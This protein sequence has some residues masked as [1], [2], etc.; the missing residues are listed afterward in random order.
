MGIVIDAFSNTPG[1]HAAACTLAAFLRL[2]LIKIIKGDELPEM[3]S[4]SYRTFGYGGFLKYTLVFV[5][6]HHLALY[7]LESLTIFDPLFL[8]MR[9]GMGVVITT[10]LICIVDA[11]NIDTQ[12]NGE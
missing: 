8:L 2:L 7:L 4:P 3:I 12:K 1:M 9:I 6:I 10:L 5:V 11:F